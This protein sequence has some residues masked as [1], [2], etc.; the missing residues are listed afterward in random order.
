MKVDV[1]QQPAS[2][3]GNMKRKKKLKNYKKLQQVAGKIFSLL[4]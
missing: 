3:I 2:T 4:F 1:K